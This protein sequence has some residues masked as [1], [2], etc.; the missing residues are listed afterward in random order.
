MC[1]KAE[2]LQYEWVLRQWDFCSK[3]GDYGD[4]SADIVSQKEMSEEEIKNFKANYVWLPREYDIKDRML[5]WGNP[6]LRDLALDRYN[7]Y[8]EDEERMKEIEDKFKDKVDDIWD[9]K[10]LIFLMGHRFKSAWDFDRQDWVEI[11]G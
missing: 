6:K 8:L 7:K 11:Q 3:K 10:A 9:V 5:G 2:R 4:G 1:E